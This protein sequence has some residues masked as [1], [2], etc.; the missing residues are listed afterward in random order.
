MAE[1]YII[2]KYMKNLD[3]SAGLFRGIKDVAYE[4]KSDALLRVKEL[5]EKSYNYVYKVG[6]LRLI[7]KSNKDTATTPIIKRE[8]DI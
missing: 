5:N 2:V 6:T 3:Y 8:L 4:S 1:V 7:A